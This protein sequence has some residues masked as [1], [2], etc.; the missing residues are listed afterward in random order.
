LNHLSATEISIH[1]DYIIPIVLVKMDD[2]I[3]VANIKLNDSI[4]GDNVISF[5]ER[6]FEVLA[7]CDRYQLPL[8]IAFARTTHSA[9][10]I[11]AT[12]SL[13]YIP[14]TPFDKQFAPFLA[15]VAVSRV[16]EMKRLFLLHPLTRKHFEI[17]DLKRNCIEKE[18]KRLRSIVNII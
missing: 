4:Y 17:S 15:Y 11:T 14:F 1:K 7:K 8:K 18:Y 9:Q 2:T 12:E 5:S 6:P 16:G 10:G 3:I 13:V